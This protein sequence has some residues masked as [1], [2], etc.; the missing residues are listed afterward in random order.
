MR[1]RACGEPEDGDWAVT[2]HGPRLKGRRA[3]AGAG[4]ALW[5]GARLGPGGQRA[6]GAGG[7]GALRRHG[8]VTALVTSL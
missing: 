6:G 4:V 8:P 5:A 3:G 2:G 7:G 1:G